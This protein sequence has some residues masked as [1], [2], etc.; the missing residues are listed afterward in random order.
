MLPRL[1]TLLT[2]L[3]LSAFTRCTKPAVHYLRPIPMITRDSRE[4]FGCRINGIPFSPLATDSSSLGTCTYRKAYDTKEGFIFR[5]NGDRHESAC[6][7]SSVTIVLDSIGLEEGKTY[8]LGSPGA[9]KNYAVYFIVKECGNTGEQMTTA[10]DLYGYVK[11]DRVNHEKQI[12]TGS[13]DFNVRDENGNLFR[14][15]DGVFDRHY[16]N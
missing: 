14:M 3:V 13:F 6:A 16:T 15:S 1:R 10:D 2:L 9:K 4:L 11:I 7:F 5:I 12:V 8:T